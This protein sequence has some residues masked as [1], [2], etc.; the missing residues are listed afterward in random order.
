[1][2]L[3]DLTGDGRK[4]IAYAGFSYQFGGGLFVLPQAANGSFGSPVRYERH[5]GAIT[6]GDVNHDGRTD[7]AAGSDRGIEYSLQRQGRLVGP[8]IVPN[9]A[10][11]LL[12]EV[13]DMNRDRR[14]DFVYSVNGGWIRMAR[15]TG[16]G[17]AISTISAGRLPEDIDVGDVTGDG[18]KDIVAVWDPTFTVFRQR[19][20]G[21]FR[22]LNYPS[23]YGIQSVEIADVTGDGRNDVSLSVARNSPAW[24]KVYEQNGASALKSPASYD[25]FQIPEALESADLDADG[26]LDLVTYHPAWITLGVYLQ[27]FDGAMEVEDL[28]SAPYSGR[29]ARHLALGDVTGD[30]RVDIVI[31]VSPYGGLYLY[32]QMPRRPLPAVRYTAQTLRDQFVPGT[33]DIGLHC[34]DCVQPITLP[35]PV[36]FYGEPVTAAFVGSNGPIFFDAP[37]DPKWTWA[38]PCAPAID[39]ERVVFALWD[40]L[41][42]ERPGTGIFTRL[43]GAAPNRTFV[44]EWRTEYLDQYAVNFEVVFREGSDVISF[45]YGPRSYYQAWSATAGIQRDQGNFTDVVCNRPEFFADGVRVDLAPV[46]NPPPPPTA[47]RQC[48][49]PRVVGLDLGRAKKKI[50]AA[51]CS[52][53]R[54]RRARSRRFGRVLGQ[55]PK[56]GTVKRRGYPVRLVVGAKRRL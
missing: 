25:S 40:D 14:T 27:R 18:R 16:R 26:S 30:G 15:N 38:S 8:S 10:N 34:D 35:F 46:P 36:S 45:V 12:V 49:V 56:A 1:M 39:F 44:V 17:F 6:T 22:P 23:F 9:T 29:E 55:S 31:A 51:Q 48:R 7:V 21:T 52:V 13:A 5:G 11:A 32:K 54:I 41:S 43:L 3:A 19:R 4:D 33:Q 37:R 50:R 47:A 42:T 53:G 28:Y 20:N 24:I 2:A